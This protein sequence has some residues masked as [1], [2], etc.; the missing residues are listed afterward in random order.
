[1]VSHKPN[2]KPGVK[3]V[4]SEKNQLVKAQNEKPGGPRRKLHELLARNKKVAEQMLDGQLVSERLA[5]VEVDKRQ[6]Q[7]VS[8]N[9]MNDVREIEKLLQDQELL[10][11]P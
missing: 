1:M 9:V 3:P 4:H 7:S 5:G 6:Q 8:V 11:E 2:V 10:M